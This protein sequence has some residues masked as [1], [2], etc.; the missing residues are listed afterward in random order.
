MLAPGIELNTWWTN[1]GL[2]DDEIIQ[3]YHAHGECEQ[4]HSKVR[5]GRRAAPVRKIRDQRVDRG[6]D[7]PG[8]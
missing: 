6:V 4:Y 5:H 3:L 7:H 8:L 1:I 2:A